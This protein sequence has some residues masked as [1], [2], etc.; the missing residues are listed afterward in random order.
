MATLQARVQLCGRFAVELCGRRVDQDL[1]GRQ[2]RLLF[3]Y[4]VLSRPH[5]VSR[6]TLIDALW[7]ESPPGSAGAALTV[8]VSKLRAAVGADV[9]QGRSALWVALPEPSHVDVDDA[10]AAVHEAESRVAL[11]DWERAWPAALSAQLVGK[12]QFLPEADTPWADAWRRRLADVHVRALECY[13]A[14]CLGLGG[15]ELPSAER[16]AQRLVE[17]APLRESS[18]L[19]LMQVLATRGNVA[20][21]L[22]AYERLRGVLRDELGVDPSPAVREVYQQLL[23]SRRR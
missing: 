11:G 10:L 14:A 18:Q 4:L 3:A 6:D 20:E 19:L 8:L 23:G 1:P 22:R 15:T 13:V 17:V 5:P 2:G 9:V 12:R 21:A 16:A 7:G